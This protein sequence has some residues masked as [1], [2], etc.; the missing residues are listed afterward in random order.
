MSHQASLENRR[1]R[2]LDAQLK[3]EAGLLTTERLEHNRLI[4]DPSVFAEV[5]NFLKRVNTVRKTNASTGQD[6]RS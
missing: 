1:P 3:Q 5:M 2:P 6:L 4:D